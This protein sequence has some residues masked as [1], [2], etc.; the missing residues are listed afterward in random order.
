MAQVPPQEG[1]VELVGSYSSVVDNVLV[2]L[3]LPE[4]ARAMGHKDRRDIALQL[5]TAA[6]TPPCICDRVRAEY[7][8]VL[9]FQAAFSDQNTVERA[10]LENMRGSQQSSRYWMNDKGELVK[11]ED[12]GANQ[13]YSDVATNIAHGGSINDKDIETAA[14]NKAE[15]AGKSGLE[16]GAF[17]AMKPQ[18]CEIVPPDM[19][20]AARQCTPDIVILAA[21]EHERRHQALCRQVNNEHPRYQM[22]GEWIDYVNVAKQ[23]GGMG[24]IIDGRTLPFNAY[25]AWSQNPSNHSAD[26]AG[27]YQKEA[28]VLKTWLDANCGGP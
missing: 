2:D 5:S 20:A 13:S 8:H 17:A 22:D 7:Q 15:S 1:N 3:D 12:A 19:N 23:T 14:V 4:M 27:A 6:V 18:G 11:F 28:G 26:E 16:K 21:L 25:V 10:K 24:V 9:D